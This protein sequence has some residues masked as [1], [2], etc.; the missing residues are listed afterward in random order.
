MNRYEKVYAQK[1][2]E[3]DALERRNLDQQKAAEAMKTE[4]E[5]LTL[6]IEAA[7]QAEDRLRGRK[8]SGL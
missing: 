5:R 3:L 7:H 1:L 6:C 8:R 2:S 4:I